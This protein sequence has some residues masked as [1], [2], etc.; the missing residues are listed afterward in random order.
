M[1]GK[2]PAFFDEVYYTTSKKEGKD[3]NVKQKYTLQTM[4]SGLYKAAR[5]RASVPDGIDSSWQAI[6]AAI[7]KPIKAVA[8]TPISKPAIPFPKK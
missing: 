7:Q 4:Q 1:Q 2:L 8:P 5:S 6:A 3:A